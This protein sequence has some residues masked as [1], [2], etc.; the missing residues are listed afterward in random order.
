MAGPRPIDRTLLIRNVLRQRAA[1]SAHGAES[2][3]GAATGA[4]VHPDDVLARLDIVVSRM[5]ED[6]VG[7]PA[8]F[9]SALQTLLQHG[10]PAL[11]KVLQP[12]LSG[13]PDLSSDELASAEAIVIAD[14]SRPSF[15]LREGSFSDDHPFLGAWRDD[16]TN[17]RPALRKLAGCVGRI[18]LPEGDPTSYNGTG[19]L[20][21]AGQGLVLTNFH[22]VKHAREVSGVAMQGNGQTLTVNDK[23]VIEFSGES[24]SAVRNRW[25]VKEVRLPTGAGVSFGGL[26]AAVLR[27][28]EF[29]PHES[30]LPASAIVLSADADYSTGAGTASLVTIGFPGT[31][32]TATPPGATIDWNF[33][34]KTLFNNRFGL[35]RVAPG[36]FGQPAGS[37]PG[38]TFGHILSHDATTFGGASGSLVFAWKDEKTPAFGLHFAGATLAANY[39]V[40]LHKVADALRATGLKVA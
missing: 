35:K 9:K 7:D 30:K 21:D 12:T 24:G 33:V 2:T 22:V 16:M 17:F 34:L 26:D 18:Q 14:G 10:E 15:L 36:K 5:P 19:T 40:S 23:W 38:D 31:P 13:L 3:E 8:Q 20:V 11:K 29:D 32:D 1:R 28:E 39:A 37:V 25:L 4:D 6:E 27:I